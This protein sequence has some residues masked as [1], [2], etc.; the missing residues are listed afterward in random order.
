MSYLVL[1]RKYRPRTFDEVEGQEHVTRTLRNALRTGRLAHAYLFSGSRGVGKT[2]VARILAKAV[3]CENPR[4]GNPCNECSS[5]RE[6]TS[7]SSVDVIEIDAASNRGID[8]VRELREGVRYAPARSR[9]KIYIIDEVHMLTNEAFNALLKTLEEPPE[10]VIFVFAT[11]EPH[12]VLPT[13]LSRCQ[14]FDFRRLTLQGLV[15]QLEQVLASEQMHMEPAAIQLVARLS[16]GG[17]RDALSLLDLVGAS[18]GRETKKKPITE[19]EVAELAG[20]AGRELV[21]QTLEAVVRGE[22]A[23]IIECIARLYEHGFDVRSFY[24][25]LMGALRDALVLRSVKGAEKFLDLTE[26]ARERL[27]G[28]FSGWSAA[29][30]DHLFQILQK[31]EGPLFHSEH[32]RYV[33]EAMLLRMSQVGSLDS[34]GSLGEQLDRIE[35][36]LGGGAAAAP[37][38][39]A[40]PAPVSAGRGA[41]RETSAPAAPRA[42]AAA[43]ERKSAAGNARNGAPEVPAAG[44]ASVAGGRIV[45]EWSRILNE[46]GTSKP[47]FRHLFGGFRLLDR[48]EGRYVLVPGSAEALLKIQKML[49]P[50]DQREALG[51]VGEIVA[52]VRGLE[53]AAHVQ[54]LDTVVDIPADAP[55]R[56][57]PSGKARAA[58]A[59]RQGPRREGEVEAGPA[60]LRRLAAENPVLARVLDVFGDMPGAPII[61]KRRDS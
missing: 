7:G 51:R 14:R 4:D 46:L 26:S 31:G 21:E 27:D 25:E 39:R 55:Q 30:V 8:S 5:C 58:G 24:G 48:G 36:A 45:A 16:E 10:H 6:I 53:S 1:A 40:P 38:P 52:Q 15:D 22:G 29:Q 3:N 20:V 2:S 42:Q 34:L 59:P 33:L 37:S 47:I 61:R 28:I 41:A 12:K 9:Y 57:G 19:Q 44:G 49:D 32:Q 18:V 50:E 17:M 23:R 54:L 60:E 13:I 56:E 11:T 43:P 35:Q